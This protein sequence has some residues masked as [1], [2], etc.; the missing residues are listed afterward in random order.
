[1]SDPKQPSHVPVVAGDLDESS[2]YNAPGEPYDGV[3]SLAL[4]ATGTYSAGFTPDQSWFGAQTA[5]AILRSYGQHLEAVADFPSFQVHPQVAD[6]GGDRLDY[7]G[8]GGSAATQNN[9]APGDPP[10]LWAAGGGYI[11]TQLPHKFGNVA[12]TTLRRWSPSSGKGIAGDAANSD[13]TEEWV[14]SGSTTGGTGAENNKPNVVGIDRDSHYTI[15]LTQSRIVAIS[16]DLGDNWTFGTSLP[17]NANWSY[18]QTACVFAGKWAVTD[19]VPTTTNVSRLLISNDMD[20]SGAWTTVT[21][22]GGGDTGSEPRRLIMNADILVMLPASNTLFTWY[23]D[24]DVSATTVRI[25]PADATRTGWRGAWNE[26]IGLFL[27]GNVQGDLWTS[28]DGKTWTQIANNMAGLSVRDIVAHG[29]G[30][31]IANGDTV[32]AIDYL[33]FDRKF[34]VRLRRLYTC[35]NQANTTSAFHLINND[36]KW[37]GARVVAYTITGGGG[38]AR[39]MLEWAHSDANPHDLNNYVGR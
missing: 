2:T 18:P 23:E 3:L 28:P 10:L 34:A 39:F 35:R 25:T 12:D 27:V 26:Q 7:A 11:V 9:N 16:T 13:E 14:E 22:V 38:N 19:Y 37:Y 5:N 36:G 15:S 24:G 32:Q 8:V 6:T 17:A 21:G 30:F 33:D 31:V 4:P 1:M 20:A 29:R